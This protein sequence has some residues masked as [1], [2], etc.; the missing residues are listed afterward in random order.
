MPTAAVSKEYGDMLCE[1]WLAR[2][3]IAIAVDIQEAALNPA[4]QQDLQSVVQHLLE[5]E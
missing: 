1:K 3:A 5:P 2:E 4:E